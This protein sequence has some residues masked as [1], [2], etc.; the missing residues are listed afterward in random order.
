MIK[1]RPQTAP[2]E[3]KTWYH[4]LVFF[5]YI[6]KLSLL[7][8]YWYCLS[9][10][11]Y[12]IIKTN[13]DLQVSLK[14]SGDSIKS[15]YLNPWTSRDC[16]W[17]CKLHSTHFKLYLTFFLQNQTSPTFWNW[18]WALFGPRICGDQVKKKGPNKKKRQF[19][20]MFVVQLVSWHN[21]IFILVMFSQ[22]SFLCRWFFNFAA[23]LF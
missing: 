9:N 19:D 22:E 21:H 16:N 23:I 13:K 20:T 8:F 18:N 10:K 6:Q 1:I 15:K 5:P 3:K 12:Y 7:F 17:L 4:R 14:V 11:R 2:N